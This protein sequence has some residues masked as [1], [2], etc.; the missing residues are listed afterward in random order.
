VNTIITFPCEEG[1][2]SFFVSIDGNFKF[3]GFTP[4]MKITFDIQHIDISYLKKIEQNLK[5]I[6]DEAI[7]NGSNGESYKIFEQLKK[8]EGRN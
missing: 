6:H 1:K 3:R 4:V 7:K 8:N 5:E 2:H